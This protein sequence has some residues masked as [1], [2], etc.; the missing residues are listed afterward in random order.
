MTGGWGGLMRYMACSWSNLAFLTKKFGVK[1]HNNATHVLTPM[2]WPQA[3]FH[4]TIK[5]VNP[6]QINDCIGL[7]YK[8]PKHLKMQYNRPETLSVDFKKKYKKSQK[9][10]VCPKT[11]P[12]VGLQKLDYLEIGESTCKTMQPFCAL[13]KGKATLFKLRGGECWTWRENK[14]ILK[15]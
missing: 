3:I 14:E 6:P 5:K 12:G 15:K 1:V 2:P 8:H 13:K 4:R 11:R 10:G 7:R 9:L